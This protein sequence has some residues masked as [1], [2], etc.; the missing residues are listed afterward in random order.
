MAAAATEQK[1]WEGGV[2]LY[3][4]GTDYAQVMSGKHEKSPL[5]VRAL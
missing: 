5:D 2:L 3:C 4:G 1:A